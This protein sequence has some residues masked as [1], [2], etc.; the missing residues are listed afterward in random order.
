MNRI[1]AA[2][3]HAAQARVDGA[4]ALSRAFGDYQYKD[5]KDLSAADQAVSPFPDVLSFQRDRDDQF[6]VVACDGIW[7]C[8]SNEECAARMEEKIKKFNCFE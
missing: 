8:V 1:V 5:Q 3:H 2:N 7:D 6:M 4:L